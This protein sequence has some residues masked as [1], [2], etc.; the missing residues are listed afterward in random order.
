[1]EEVKELQ[2][3]HPTT[4]TKLLDIASAKCIEVVRY[5][6]LADFFPRELKVGCSYL[7]DKRIAELFEFSSSQLLKEF[8]GSLENKE[9]ILFGRS[10]RFI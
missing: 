2:L 9:R 1:L 5:Q 6:Y 7:T 8:W 3:K 10:V 4:F